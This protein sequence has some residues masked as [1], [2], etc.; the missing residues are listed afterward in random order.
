MTFVK[1][2]GCGGSEVNHKTVSQLVWG[3][4]YSAVHTSP[5]GSYAKV[6]A[7]LMDPAASSTPVYAS[8]PLPATS[9]CP[10]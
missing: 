4:Q 6:L 3:T 8:P 7:L 2:H 1:M 10:Q 9:C 5:Q